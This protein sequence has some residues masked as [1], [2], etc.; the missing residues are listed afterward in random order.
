MLIMGS[1]Q[2][3]TQDDS[4]NGDGIPPVPEWQLDPTASHELPELIMDVD[5]EVSNVF[6]R[7]RNIFQRNEN[8]KIPN[9]QLHDLTSFVIHRLLL[10]PDA[11]KAP[12]SPASEC[13]RCAII[14][15]MLVIQGPTYYS[16]ASI[17]NTI[18]IDFME[19]LN[20]LDT[21]PRVYCSLDIWLIAIG[22]VASTGT[23]HYRSFLERA[24]NISRSLQLIDAEDV[25][26]RIK[27]ILWLEIINAERTFTPHWEAIMATETRPLPLERMCTS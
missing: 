3:N 1:P 7:L 12:L 26:N 6:I 5:H 25:L 19:N 10:P 24:S 16:H 9:T 11:P 2:F 27:S 15:Y 20:R 14:L 18:V 22:L 8:M 21:T 17:S 23:A 4:G 13:I